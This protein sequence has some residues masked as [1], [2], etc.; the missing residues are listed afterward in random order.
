M[1]FNYIIWNVTPRIADLGPLEL[2]WYGIL[3]SMSFLLGFIVLNK[4]FVKEGF[5]DKLI[6][7][8]A[9]YLL[10]G[11][12]AGLRL[13]H[14]LFYEPSYYLSN[15]IEILKVWK[16]GLAS[17]GAAIGVLTAL[18]L[19]CRKVKKPF[20]WILDRVVIIVMVIAP[21]IRLGNL[22]NSEII[23]GR[24]QVPWA[25][26]FVNPVNEALAEK[27]PEYID[28][29][30]IISMDRDT[31]I[32]DSVYSEMRADVYFKNQ[33]LK[34][35][36]IHDFIYRMFM[37]QMSSDEDLVYNTKI[38]APLPQIE[39]TDIPRYHKASFTFYAIPRHP[40]QLY[41]SLFYALMFVFLLF[42]YRRSKGNF[43]NGFMLGMFLIILWTFRFLV[44]FLKE[45][46][47]DFEKDIFLNMGQ[48]L[49]I[50]FII[51]GIILLVRAWGKPV[52]KQ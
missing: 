51:V 17:H 7:K 8:L 26:L 23:G 34:K 10:V 28:K 24:T 31:V 30:K 21:F 32:N 3:F 27:Y 33:G 50:P 22:A 20:L 5:S 35:E 12:I 45:V 38:F 42:Y 6:S 39:I 37:P 52:A 43:K 9:I 49:S 15:P 47:V 13:G 2:R 19:Y 46:Q 41:E 44:E 36:Q 18:Y 48:L 29:T 14:C 11:T 1:T 25:F 4:I 16:G 40:S